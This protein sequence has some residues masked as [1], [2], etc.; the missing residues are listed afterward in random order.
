MSKPADK[1]VFTVILVLGVLVALVAAGV[2]ALYY[3]GE[4][5]PDPALVESVQNEYSVPVEVKII[6][7]S[8]VNVP[9][10]VPGKV[11]WDSEHK[12]LLY[13]LSD[14]KEVTLA[15][16]EMLTNRDEQAL[17]ILMSQK[18][19]DYWA[20]KGYSREQM[21]EKLLENYGDI[22]EPYV[23]ALEP[24]ESEPEAGILSVLIKHVSHEKEL[25]L[26]QQADGTWKI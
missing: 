8:G 18:N 2:A 1:I 5:S 7:T 25:M 15:A 4:R 24:E 9:Y 6:N 16:I 3:F 13:N 22:D 26:T 17:D 19:K 12:N 10:I 14:P 21:I 23:F 11:K 20:G